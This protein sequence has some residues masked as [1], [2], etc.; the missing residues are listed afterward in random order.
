MAAWVVGEGVSI[1]TV[2][3]LKSAYMYMQDTMGMRVVR[4]I[5]GFVWRTTPMPITQLSI[6]CEVSAGTD[7]SKDDT[8]DV[9]LEQAYADALAAGLASAAS[10]AH[11]EGHIVG[12]TK[13]AVSPCKGLPPKRPNEQKPAPK[14]AWAAEGA[15]PSKK[16]CTLNEFAK[17]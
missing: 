6:D 15:A 9:T 3:E 5:L 12:R 2:P 16:L 14:R 13:R 17:A 1:H 11:A 8:L 10:S 7:A 4:S